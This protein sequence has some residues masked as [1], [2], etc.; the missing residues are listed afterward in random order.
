M[1][2]SHRSGNGLNSPAHEADVLSRKP[3]AYTDTLHLTD[4]SYS[5][6]LRVPLP[7]LEDTIRVNKKA[8]ALIWKDGVATALLLPSPTSLLLHKDPTGPKTWL[9]HSDS[10]TRTVQERKLA[11]TT[12][13]TN[14]R[15]RRYN[16]PGELKI[17]LRSKGSP[18]ASP[19]RL[20]AHRQNHTT[21]ER[22]PEVRRT[23]APASEVNPWVD[24]GC[25]HSAEVLIHGQVPG[26]TSWTWLLLH[27]V[28]A[29][30]RWSPKDALSL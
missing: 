4:C 26:K 5:G 25:Q 15:K 21:A 19:D 14:E 28:G 13:N 8:E 2:W 10:P 18:L 16:Q 11:G 17:C 23:N 7:A 24:V 20:P 29:E 3:K 30:A 1:D 6:P 22:S 12:A 27:Q 9:S